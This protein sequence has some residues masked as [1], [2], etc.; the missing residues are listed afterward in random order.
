M[1]RTPAF[2]KSKFRAFHRKF[3]G[4]PQRLARALQCTPQT[5]YNYINKFGLETRAKRGKKPLNA[6]DLKFIRA[7]NLDKTINDLI[8]ELEKNSAQA[9]AAALMTVVRKAWNADR[10]PNFPMPRTP[11]EL[12]VFN[13]MFTLHKAKAKNEYGDP[14]VDDIESVVKACEGKLREFS[15][16]KYHM[17]YLAFQIEGDEDEAE[18]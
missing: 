1:A 3:K 7:F 10:Y 8:L 6:A 17:K 5:V 16:E 13:T 12:K 18:A 14:A 9:A 2:T 11:V 4:D 15:I